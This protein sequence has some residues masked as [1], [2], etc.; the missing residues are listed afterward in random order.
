MHL[1]AHISEPRYTLC[2]REH[3]LRPNTVKLGF[4]LATQH[5][6]ERRGQNHTCCDIW[7]CDDIWTSALHDRMPKAARGAKSTASNVHPTRV[8]PMSCG[9]ACGNNACG[10]IRAG[11]SSH[12]YIAATSPLCLVALPPLYGTYAYAP[13]RLVWP[14]ARSWHS[15]GGAGTG[16]WA[17]AVE[18]SIMGWIY[19][20]RTA[21]TP[22]HHSVSIHE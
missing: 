14:V 7:L 5:L 21:S 8:C 22:T 9:I 10:L 20:E 18:V 17:A 6:C 12:I 4:V 16:R 19:C 13:P 1:G 3:A 15:W 11:R 2:A